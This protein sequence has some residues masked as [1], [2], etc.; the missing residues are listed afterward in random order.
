MDE[1]DFPECH[2]DEMVARMRR[3]PSCVVEFIHGFGDAESRRK[4]YKLAQRTFSVPTF[5]GRCLDALILVTRAGIEEGLRQSAAATSRDTA[6]ELKNFSNVLSYNLSADLAECWPEDSLPREKRHFEAG[7]A[8]ANDCL[9]WR[10][11]LRKGPYPFSIAWWAHGMHSLS[12]G[13][14][15]DAAESFD[16]AQ[17]F[18][19]QA[20]KTLGHRHDEETDFNVVLNRGYGGWARKLDGNASGQEQYARACERF[21]TIAATEE[22]EAKNDAEFGLSQLRCI[23]ARIGPERANWR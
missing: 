6:D 3:D 14:F 5:E 23:A 10:L 22:G 9:R 21:T 2:K 17:D 20:A 13:L 15:A 19:M 8:A 11:E 7:L 18:G 12:L 4:L 1:A 16:K